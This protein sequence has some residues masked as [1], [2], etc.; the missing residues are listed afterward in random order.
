MVFY[1]RELWSY[2]WMSNGK[3]GILIVLSIDACHKCR[4]PLNILR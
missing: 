3:G 1:G 4:S 2:V